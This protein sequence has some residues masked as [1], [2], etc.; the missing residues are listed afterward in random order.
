M[1]SHL[2]RQAG[3]LAVSAYF[4]GLQCMVSRVIFTQRV[5][6]HCRLVHLLLRCRM[7]WVDCDMAYNTCSCT[8]VD[9]SAVLPN[10]AAATP[11]PQQW[12][13]GD[14]C[15]HSVYMLLLSPPPAVV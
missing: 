6:L 15:S 1:R 5:H 3:Q 10:A 9:A 12:S 4:E 8:A 13:E 7:Q 2:P 14:C 11:L